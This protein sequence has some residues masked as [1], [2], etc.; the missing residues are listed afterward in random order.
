[1]KFIEV[2]PIK[3]ALEKFIKKADIKPVGVEE[4]ETLKAYGRVLAENIKSEKNIPPF[5]RAAMDGY[6]VKA[7]D[8]FG[9]S[10]QN[11]KKLKITGKILIGEIPK[12]KVGFGEAVEVSTGSMVPEGA[13]AVLMLEHA[14]KINNEIIVFKATSCLLYTSPSPRDRG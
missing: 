13:N 5:N 14:E 4:V 2:M 3:E 11:P 8:T 7:E 1:M 10:P 6:A 12:V 9:A